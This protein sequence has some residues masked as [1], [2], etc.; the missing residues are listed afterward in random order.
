MTFKSFG[1][2]ILYTH[3]NHKLSYFYLRHNPCKLFLIPPQINWFSSPS[4]QAFGV[5]TPL[6]S[7]VIYVMYG[8]WETHSLIQCF[9]RESGNLLLYLMLFVKASKPMV[10]S[11]VINKQKE[12]MI[13]SNLMYWNFGTHFCI[14]CYILNWS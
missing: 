6:V 9:L 10:D 14:W 7:L 5:A 8:S 11:D 13:M 2:K 3:N 4:S 12:T 1:L